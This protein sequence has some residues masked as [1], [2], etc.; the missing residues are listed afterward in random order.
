VSR[1]ALLRIWSTLGRNERAS[2]LAYG[3]LLSERAVFVG[4]SPAQPL[5]RPAEETIVTAV[6]RLTRSYPTLDRRRL[7]A[8]VAELMGAHV[9]GSRPLAEVIDELEGVYERHYR[10]QLSSDTI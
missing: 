1:D 3:E 5:S 10:A 4:S 9:L 2:L 6:R 8:E 7:M